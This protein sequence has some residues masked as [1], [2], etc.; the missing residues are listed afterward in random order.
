VF[1]D[2]REELSKVDYG[3]TPDT[4]GEIRRR[5]NDGLIAIGFL[6]AARDSFQCWFRFFPSLDNGGMWEPETRALLDRLWKS[7]KMGRVM[8][9]EA[10]H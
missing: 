9:E 2:E 3:P 1:V 6:R 4:I 5:I 8:D 7:G 10:I